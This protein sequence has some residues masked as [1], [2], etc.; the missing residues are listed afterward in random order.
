MKESAPQMLL[1]DTVAMMPL[2][3]ASELAAVCGINIR[4]SRRLLATSRA[5]GWTETVPHRV[6]GV[7]TERWRLTGAGVGAFA[8][9]KGIT[10]KEAL[11]EWPLSAQWEQ[12]LLRR[13]HTVGLCY[14]IAVEALR[15][16]PGYP[17][18]RWERSD[19]FDAFMTLSSGRTFGICRMGAAL[20]VDSIRSRVDA[21]RR[22]RNQGHIDSAVV[23]TPGPIEQN[24]LVR[25]L[26]RSHI[27]L[28]VGTEEK[29]LHGGPGESAWRTPLYKPLE[30]FPLEPFINSSRSQP[31]PPRRRKPKQASMPKGNDALGPESPELAASSLGEAGML[32]LDTASNWPLITEER[33]QKITGFNSSWFREQRARLVE[34]GVLARVSMTSRRAGGRRL[35]LT[36][37]G[38]RLIAWRDRTTLSDLTRGWRI[39]PGSDPDSKSFIEGHEIRGTKLRVAAR[40]IGH[41]DA[42]QEL[43]CLIQESCA[44]DPQWEVVQ[45]LPTHRWERWFYY[46]NRRYGIRPDATALLRCSGRHVA[47][48]VEYEQSAMTPKR[49]LE[50]VS[51][52]TRYFGSLDTGLDFASPPVAL[53]VFPDSAS[54]SRFVVHLSRSMIAP[55]GGRVSRFRMLSSSLE[56]V[57][58]NGFTGAAW[59]DP[60]H[61][62]EGMSTLD[63]CM[64]RM[65]KW[66]GG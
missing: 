59:W 31:I 13:L 22:L 17:V 61:V 5:N 47:L 45:I 58:V 44:D 29:V 11:R 42:L 36:D 62:D 21:L 32:L 16:D 34:S 4:R 7:S 66:R 10:V 50:K 48:L 8:E 27:N 55:R 37:D 57:Y 40:E 64:Q 49:M 15:V 2:L 43:A 38:L 39:A 12:S 25:R 65:F 60:L 24:N 35:V 30:D 41:T 54:A 46:N 14:R 63:G 26:E 33:A 9:R 53:M 56:D 23:I 18:W 52:Y 28:A 51:R 20:S 19:V 1:L 3:S 6:A